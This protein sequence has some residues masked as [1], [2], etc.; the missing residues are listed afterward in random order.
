MLKLKAIHLLSIPVTYVYCNRKNIL[1]AFVGKVLNKIKEMESRIEVKPDVRNMK[2]M[3]FYSLGGLLLTCTGIFKVADKVNENEFMFYCKKLNWFHHLNIMDIH[4]KV[5]GLSRNMEFDF[6]K[7][8]YSGACLAMS[9][10]FIEKFKNNVPIANILEN[11]KRGCPNYYFYELNPKL[12]EDLKKLKYIKTCSEDLVNLRSGIYL[13]CS[14]YKN[15]NGHAIVIIVRKDETIVF[16]PNIGIINFNPTDVNLKLVTII[17]K[18][19]S[20]KNLDHLQLFE[21]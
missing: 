4:D 9:M 16:D 10:E 20:K 1:N 15:M 11:F 12:N 3:S 7:E 13:V 14:S 2:I 19:L 6:D 21:F 5:Y 18:L 17:D 8:K